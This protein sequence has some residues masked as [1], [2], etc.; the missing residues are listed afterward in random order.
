MEADDLLRC[1]RC[2]TAY[3]RVGGVWDMKESQPTNDS[4]TI[5]IGCGLASKRKFAPGKLARKGAMLY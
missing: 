3:R 2:A 5:G 4:S 1:E